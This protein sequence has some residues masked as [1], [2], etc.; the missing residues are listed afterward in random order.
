MTPPTEVVVVV[1]SDLAIPTELDRV[2]VSVT[3]P[4]GEQRVSEG[5]LASAAGLPATVG[6]VHRGGPLGDARVLVEGVRGTDTVVA[7]R[8]SFAWQ[9]NQTLALRLDL[10]RAC[11]SITCEPMETCGEN[12]CRLIA[13]APDEL[14]PYPPPP[15]RDAS[16]PDAAVQDDAGRSDAGPVDASVSSDGS[17]EQ[18]G[19]LPVCSALPAQCEVVP[20]ACVCSAC[21]CSPQCSD[22]CEFACT[23]GSRCRIQGEGTT[24]IAG[25]C[26]ASTCEIAARGSQNA[27][28]AC[29]NGAQCTVDCRQAADCGVVCRDTSS[30]VVHCNGAGRC[31]MANC[32]P[33]RCPGNILVCN[34]TCP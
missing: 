17:I 1:D 29:L 7:R 9:P 27:A 3:G 5:A 22:D 6:L 24:R 16:V 23:M 33:T 8:A 21:T 18:D 10:L 32:T 11:L 25:R 2:R 14:A 30:C 31:V 34:A 26:S 13:V 15:R 12:G 19:G 28:I 4:S 20:R